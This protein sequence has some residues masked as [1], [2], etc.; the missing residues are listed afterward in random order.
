MS[1]EIL[2]PKPTLQAWTSTPL[3]PE[4]WRCV[5]GLKLLS[6]A[7]GTACCP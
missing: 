5:Q 1:L 4:M 7:T 2:D 3:Q 6:E